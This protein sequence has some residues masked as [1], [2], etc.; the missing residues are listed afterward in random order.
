MGRKAEK[1]RVHYQS[2]WDTHTHTHTHTHTN[3]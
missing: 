2:P 1:V 3:M